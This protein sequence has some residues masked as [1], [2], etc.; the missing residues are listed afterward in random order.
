MAT[1]ITTIEDFKKYVTVNDS[2]DFAIIQPYLKRVDR[3]HIKPLI[4]NALYDSIG[5]AQEGKSQEV[6]ELLQEASANLAMFSFSMVGKVQITSSGF[7]ISQGQNN[8]VAGWA[9]MRDMRRNFIKTGSEAIDEALKIM[10]ENEASFQEWVG[11][12][13]YTT[14][15]ELFTRRTETFNRYFII[16]NSRLTF[17]RLKPN[18]LKV[19]KKFFRGLLGTETVNL[20]KAGATPEAK[21]ALKLAQAAQVPLCVAEVAKE[22]I[23]TLNEKG[24]VFE[25]E[26]IPGER[27]IK[28]DQQELDRIYDSK[29]EEG[30]EALK[31][32]VAYL[33]E[34]PAIFA[35]F[36]AKEANVLSNPVHN[37]KSIVSF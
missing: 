14:F 32:L 3:K 7:L 17:L 20:I 18:L 2:F 1:L 15:K 33:R 9:E 8:Q 26:E 25:I 34:Y 30:T 24:I 11:T 37:N 13:G 12:E 35:A 29:L 36:A 22:G 10:E 16:Q 19:E 4:G 27:K 31:E 28:T 23:F 21:E 5:A 6:L